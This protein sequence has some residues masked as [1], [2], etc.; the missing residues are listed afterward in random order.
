MKFEIETKSIRDWLMNEVYP[1]VV[2]KQM[3]TTM[4]PNPF[5]LDCWAEGMPWEDTIGGG[6]TYHFTPTSLGYITKASYTMGDMY[7]EKDFTEYD[8]W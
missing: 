7:F 2:E 8:E 6:L 4:N 5:Q 3:A 1:E